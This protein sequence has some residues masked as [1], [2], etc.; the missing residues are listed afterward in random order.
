MGWDKKTDSSPAQ[1]SAL[2]DKAVKAAFL[3]AD[4]DDPEP[5]PTRFRGG[6][7]PFDFA[8]GRLSSFL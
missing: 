5:S 6:G 8:Q 4:P 3:S 7:P 2:N 1:P